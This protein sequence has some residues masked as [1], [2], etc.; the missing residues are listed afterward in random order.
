MLR[1]TFLT[2]VALLICFCFL[3]S[4]VFA[5]SWVSKA[6]KLFENDEYQKVISFTE[7][8]K[9]EK[10]GRMFLA[11][12]HLQ[13]SIFNKTKYDKEKFKGYNMWLEAKCGINDISNILYFINLN[14][15]PY[16]VK[17]ARKLAKKTFKNINKIEDVP[18]LLTF[19]KSTDVDSRKLAL[20]T[21]T[22][23]LTPKRKYVNDGGTMRSKDIQIMGSKTLI[24]SLLENVQEN[25]AKKALIIIEEPV[26]QFT[27]QFAGND[28]TKLETTINKK[29]A[30]RKK[31]YPDSNWYSAT[32]KNR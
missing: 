6:K 19:L 30:K 24:T 2:L 11:Y 22:R 29:I 5:Q 3:S 16:V 17:E 9:K 31:K 20:S 8:K 1:K 12:S 10:M 7:A 4:G 23:I 18:T 21:I 26:L 32:G 14:D 28:T 15:K 13:E 27:G 25:N